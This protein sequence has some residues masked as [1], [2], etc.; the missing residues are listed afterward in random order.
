MV[1]DGRWMVEDLGFWV[2]DSAGPGSSRYQLVLRS[3]KGLGQRRA[4][5]HQDRVRTGVGG[6]GAWR[7]RIVHP[8][9]IH[10]GHLDSEMYCWTGSHLG[11]GTHAQEHCPPS[12]CMPDTHSTSFSAGTVTI[13]ATEPHSFFL[14]WWEL[15]LCLLTHVHTHKAKI[16]QCGISGQQNDV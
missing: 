2:G 13:P 8:A 9:Y 6:K 7:A 14:C 15:Y 3:G 1:A 12:L 11:T 4:S 5:E 10:R 16:D